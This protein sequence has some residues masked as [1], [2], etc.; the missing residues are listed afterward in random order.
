MLRC[1]VANEHQ[2]LLKKKKACRKR[3][4]KAAI[5]IKHLNTYKDNSSTVSRPQL[6]TQRVRNIKIKVQIKPVALFNL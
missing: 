3:A 4:L 5:A 2:I 1:H 6:I